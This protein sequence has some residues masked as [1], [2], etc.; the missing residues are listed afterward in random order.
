MSDDQEN[1]KDVRYVHVNFPALKKALDSKS[2]TLSLNFSE[3]EAPTEVILEEVN[4]KGD[5][6]YVVV[7]RVVGDSES[8]V[9][10]VMNDDAFVGDVRHGDGKGENYELRAK[11]SGLFAIRVPDGDLEEPCEE[12]EEAAIEGENPI[13]D[14]KATAEGKASPLATP[15]VRVLGAYTPRA[16]INQ[17]G[18]TAIVALIQKGIADTNRA[19]TDSGINLKVELAG[20]ME[21][22]SN[23]SS[24]M[25]SD[26]SALRS[27]TDSRFNDVH[28]KR[29][30]VRADQVSLIGSYKGYSTAAGIGYVRASYSNAFTVTKAQ[31]FSQYTFSHELGH[32]LGLNHSDGYQNSAGRFRTIIA[33][34]SYPR[35]RRYSNPN[36]TYNGYRT[37]TASHN[38]SSILRANAT[39]MA[40]LIN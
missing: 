36:M 19:L 25:S 37:G 9:S 12:R 5:N 15:V 18:T 31:Y 32:N 38:E 40:S 8:E 17:G 22:K 28:A 30:S 35:I 16:R 27:K 14:I 24:S 4:K 1:A 33:Y 26:L 29:T 34:G 39:R 20:T 13:G 11:G 3:D 2:G 23:E 6:N 21:T 10:L 7:G